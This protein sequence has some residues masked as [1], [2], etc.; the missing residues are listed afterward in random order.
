MTPTS[1]LSAV[2]TPGG[3]SEVA[4]VAEA[5]VLEADAR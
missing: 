4:E 3:Q 2:G 5:L 1:G